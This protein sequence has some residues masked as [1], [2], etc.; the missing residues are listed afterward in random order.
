MWNWPP[1]LGMI[2]FED[3]TRITGSGFVVYRGAGA[4][5]NAP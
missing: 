1:G 5:W 3:G 2:S 4:V